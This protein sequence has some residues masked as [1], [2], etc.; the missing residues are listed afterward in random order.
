[1]IDVGFLKRFPSGYY[2]HSPSLS[3]IAISFSLT[4]FVTTTIGIKILCFILLLVRCR[5]P[6]LE[7]LG[8]YLSLFLFTSLSGVE[9]KSP[10]QEYLNEITH[11]F[12]DCSKLL[13]YL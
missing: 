1:M 4:A 3:C 12:G 9:A 10:T 13:V 7:V 2:A 5:F 6:I 11:E 8:P